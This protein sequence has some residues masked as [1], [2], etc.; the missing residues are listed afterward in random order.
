MKVLY[1]RTQPVARA[2]LVAMTKTPPAP[3]DCLHR[4]KERDEKR[5]TGASEFFCLTFFFRSLFPS[6]DSKRAPATSN[7]DDSDHQTKEE[8]WQNLAEGL[9]SNDYQMMEPVVTADP[10]TCIKKLEDISSQI[11]RLC[12]DYRRFVA[13]LQN[14]HFIYLNLGE[15]RS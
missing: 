13:P 6:N 10:M 8:A 4:T 3:S 9:D 1:Y 11:S 14:F 12:G 15:W 2:R 5:V 7:E